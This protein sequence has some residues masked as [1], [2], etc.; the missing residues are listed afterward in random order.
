LT[1]VPSSRELEMQERVAREESG[2]RRIIV[3]V[4]LGSGIVL[5]ASTFFAWMN[6]PVMIH[7]T[8]S[9][10]SYFVRE[11][12][13]TIGLAT[14][15]AG[16][17]AL[18]LGVI[19]VAT[20]VSFRSG[21]GPIGWFAVGLALGAVSDEAAEIIQLLLGRRI[22]LDHFPTGVIG[23]AQSPLASAI[24]AGVWMA[25]LAS[26]ALLANALT[27]LWLARRQWN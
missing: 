17:F 5:I 20:A 4:Q 9:S 25:A 2:D 8:R 6:H 22:W 21:R 10:P 19:A 13:H 16:L 1:S 27:Y 23:S 15:P 24:G 3:R 26:V 12:S 14:V 11:V 18:G 7:R